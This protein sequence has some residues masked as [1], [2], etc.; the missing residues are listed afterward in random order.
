MALTV[1]ASGTQLAVIGTEHSL[2][3][4]SFIDSGMYMVNVNTR[5]MLAAD[6]LELRAYVKI[7]T[8]DAQ[9]YL[10]YSAS[11]AGVQGDAAAPGSSAKGDVTKHSIPVPSPYSL[12]FT[13]KQTAGT[14][15]NFDWSVVTI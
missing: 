6:V 12:R 9:E 7:L 10:A 11:F 3:A 2:N 14:G 15:R 8:G 13:L 1:K 5:N 4:G